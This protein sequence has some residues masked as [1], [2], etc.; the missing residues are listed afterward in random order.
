MVNLHLPWFSYTIYPEKYTANCLNGKFHCMN[1]RWSHS[2]RARALNWQ[3]RVPFCQRESHFACNFHNLSTRI[4]I[5]L[6]N[7]VVPSLMNF[8]EP[9]N[10]SIGKK[11]VDDESALRIWHRFSFLHGRKTH[12][13]RIYMHVMAVIYY[14]FM[15]L[16]YSAPVYVNHRAPFDSSRGHFLMIDEFQVEKWCRL[17]VN[18]W[19]MHHQTAKNKQLMSHRTSLNRYPAPIMPI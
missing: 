14:L 5:C 15:L 8:A 10:S 11:T 3:T 13:S 18:L 7:P 6:E 2:P 9:E 12:Q 1:C 19:Q 4:S 17:P 16:L